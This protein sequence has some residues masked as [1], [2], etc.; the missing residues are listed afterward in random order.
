MFFSKIVST[1]EKTGGI[2]KLVRAMLFSWG[3]RERDGEREVKGCGKMSLW[4]RKGRNFRR[5][6]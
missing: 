1:W 4:E 5:E 2:W 3:R 6:I